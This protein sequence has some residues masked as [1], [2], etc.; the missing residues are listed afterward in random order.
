MKNLP[1]TLSAATMIV[2]VITIQLVKSV[3]SV[4]AAKPVE[5]VNKTTTRKGSCLAHLN[6]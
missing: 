6:L 5:I 1:A 3:R 2:L 4:K